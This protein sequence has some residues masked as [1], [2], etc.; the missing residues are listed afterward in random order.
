MRNSKVNHK[1]NT[2]WVGDLSGFED[3]TYFETIFKP[4][5]TIKSIKIMRNESNKAKYAFI[6]FFN[7]ET[8]E[9]VISTYRNQKMPL[10]GK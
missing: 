10:S 7:K 2:I 8:A 5:H 6:E 4:M 1:N 9:L 3:K